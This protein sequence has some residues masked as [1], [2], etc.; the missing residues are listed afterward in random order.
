MFL[1]AT[2]SYF[3]AVFAA[4]FALGSIRVL[5]VAPRTGDMAAVALELPFMLLFAWATAGRIYRTWPLGSPA[6]RLGSGMVA[7]AMLLAAE[8]AL[9]IALIGQDGAGFLASTLSAKG[10]LGLTGQ[11]AFALIPAIRRL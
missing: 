6:R 7:F 5:A 10:L 2:A 3:A 9:A 11:V 4:G 8:M 1:K